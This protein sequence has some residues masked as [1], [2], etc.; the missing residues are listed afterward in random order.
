MIARRAVDQ[1]RGDP[2]P[3]SG[4]AYAALEH[5]ADAELPPDVADVHRPA[6]ECEGGV[7]R[8][9]GQRGNLG[10]IGSYVLADSVAEIF[11]L[12]ISAHVRERKDADRQ[13]AV[14]RVAI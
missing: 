11:L 9:D 3:A 2:N 10:Q 13:L 8:D 6:L 12:R 5:M 7:A 4:L 1:L 14:M